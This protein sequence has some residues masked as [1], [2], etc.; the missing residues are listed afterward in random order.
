MNAI[1]K[2]REALQS[3]AGKESLQK[4]RP[5]FSF[6]K[7]KLRMER[8]DSDSMTLDG[9]NKLL[10]I[11]LLRIVTGAVTS[12]NV[13]P[14]NSFDQKHGLTPVNAVQAGWCLRNTRVN[15]RGAKSREIHRRDFQPAKRTSL[16][17][18]RL[19]AESNRHRCRFARSRCENRS[20][21][22]SNSSGSAEVSSRVWRYN[23]CER[24]VIHLRP[25][26]TVCGYPLAI[27]PGHALGTKRASV[28]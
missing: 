4:R 7:N 9:R 21:V 26:R 24:L 28:L 18:W 8:L 12:R 11:R 23:R 25:C 22:S 2:P 5:A 16:V 3:G 27:R 1:G 13:R 19:Q 6:E 10:P 17:V 14:L 20:S 15:L